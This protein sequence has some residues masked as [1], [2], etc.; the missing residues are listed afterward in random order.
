M[1]PLNPSVRSKGI[2][3]HWTE[4]ERRY[5]RIRWEEPPPDR[6]PEGVVRN[7]RAQ[8]IGNITNAEVRQNL[9]Q[10]QDNL[11]SRVAP[12]HLTNE[13]GATS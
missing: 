7:E 9:Q 5:D 11:R 12:N 6:R 8:G 4:N 10:R 3:R 1:S 2:R 13:A